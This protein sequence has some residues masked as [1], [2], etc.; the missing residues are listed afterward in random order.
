M[1]YFFQMS[2]FKSSGE[3]SWIFSYRNVKS[4][5]AALSHSYLCVFLFASSTPP[6]PE[7]PL[8][9]G[10]V[11]ALLHHVLLLMDP[12]AVALEV[13]LR[14][15]RGLA[16]QVDGLVLDDVRLL[17]L[18]QEVRERLGRVRGERLREFAQSQIVIIYRGVR[19]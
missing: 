13:D 18:H 2:L 6:N 10:L 4:P 11:H 5:N 14:G 1:I 19:R 17:W 9:G 16:V 7:P 15:G 8:T 3:I 12:L